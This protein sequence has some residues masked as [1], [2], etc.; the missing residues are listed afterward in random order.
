[1]YF[2]E[3]WRLTA[4]AEELGTAETDGKHKTIT[5][6]PVR[7]ITAGRALNISYYIAGNKK[8]TNRFSVI[9]AGNSIFEL[10]TRGE[11]VNACTDDAD[12]L[13]VV[14]D[15][16]T[17][18]S[19]LAWIE[20]APVPALVK[21]AA[22]LSRKLEELRAA[23]SPEWRAAWVEYQLDYYRNH[24]SQHQDQPEYIA[25][26]AEQNGGASCLE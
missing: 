16:P 21:E 25:L 13:L 2:Y 11:Y 1:M 3:S 15:F 26:L 14:K 9:I 5:L 10:Q 23:D 18:A 20:R 12:I 4:P 22:D 8:P 17:R 19:A 6:A 24:Y 7:L